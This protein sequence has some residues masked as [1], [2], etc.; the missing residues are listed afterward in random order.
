MSYHIKKTS[1]IR[2][3]SA[4]IYKSGK[5]FRKMTILNPDI[6]SSDINDCVNNPCGDNGLCVDGVASYT[7]QCDAGWEG[8]HCEISE[9]L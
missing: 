1:N 9:Y 2:R 3:R 5:A 6:F 8:T 7:C 4:A